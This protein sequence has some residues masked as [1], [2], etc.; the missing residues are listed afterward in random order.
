MQVGVVRWTEAG[1]VRQREQSRVMVKGLGG[2]EVI[3]GEGIRMGRR[4]LKEKQTVGGRGR[5][6]SLY[7]W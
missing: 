1:F 6:A 3:G 2:T 7:T 4:W 5:K